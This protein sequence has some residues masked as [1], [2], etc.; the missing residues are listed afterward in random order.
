[1]IET[2]N[3][4][5]AALTIDDAPRAAEDF[6]GLLLGDIQIRR[7]LGVMSRPRKAQIEARAAHA[8]RAFLRLYGTAG[9][10]AKPTS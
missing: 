9:G 6:L 8:T 2:P 4:E 3:A 5:H 10:V 7:L 1:V